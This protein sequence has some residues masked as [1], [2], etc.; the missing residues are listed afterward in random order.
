MRRRRSDTGPRPRPHSP[1]DDE[2]ENEDDENED[3]KEENK[4]DPTRCSV[5]RQGQRLQRRTVCQDCLRNQQRRAMKANRIK[6][7]ETAIREAA[8]RKELERQ[9]ASNKECNALSLIAHKER[10]KVF[11]KICRR[12]ADARPPLDEKTR[13][14]AGNFMDRGIDGVTDMLLALTAHLA[15]ADNDAT[16]IS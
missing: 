5:C 4:N 11:K 2:E 8:E 9:I 15:H 10:M 3:N 7:Q 13:K 12:L 14:L 1:Q 16:Y 6:K